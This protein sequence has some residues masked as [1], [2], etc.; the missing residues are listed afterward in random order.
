[1][2]QDELKLLKSTKHRSMDIWSEFPCFQNTKLVKFILNW[3]SGDV[4]NL[5]K[6]YLIMKE[7]IETLFGLWKVGNVL[8]NNSIWNKEVETLTGVIGDQR[9]LIILTIRD[10][11]IRYIAHGVS[12]KIFFG[13]KK[14]WL[15]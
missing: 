7:V 14:V 15:W 11:V 3:M 10:M 2:S 4:L 13:T 5:D 1:M 12:Y 6:S 9:A 8:E